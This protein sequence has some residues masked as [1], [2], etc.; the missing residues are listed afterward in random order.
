MQSDVPQ[1]GG[2]VDAHVCCAAGSG[3]GF[4]PPLAGQELLQPFGGRCGF[5]GGVGV[6]Q[7]RPHTLDRDCVPAADSRPR[8]GNSP[9]WAGRQALVR[10]R[11]AAV[12]RSPR[13]S[14]RPSPLRDPRIGSACFACSSSLIRTPVALRPGP[15]WPRRAVHRCDRASARSG[16]LRHLRHRLPR[17]HTGLVVAGAT[18]GRDSPDPE[19]V[20]APC[21]APVAAAYGSSDP[22]AARSA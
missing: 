6:S 18:L 16:R 8:H 7:Q 19:Q 3:G 12:R 11:R 4:D 9:A 1:V 14:P 15:A 13:R 20:P 21:G 10:P 5:A 22:L 17:R 2:E